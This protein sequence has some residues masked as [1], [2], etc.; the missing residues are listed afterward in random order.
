MQTIHTI[1]FFDADGGVMESRKYVCDW[2]AACRAAAEY[3]DQIEA[4]DYD[5]EL[6]EAKFE[7]QF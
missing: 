5:T 2:F 7:A 1:Y 3:A 6:P 4:A